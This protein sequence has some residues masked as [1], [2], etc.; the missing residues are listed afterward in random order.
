M[1]PVRDGAI[2][3]NYIA[4]TLPTYT[5]KV[6]QKYSDDVNMISDSNGIEDGN[7]LICRYCLFKSKT[8]TFVE[9]KSL[10]ARGVELSTLI[11]MVLW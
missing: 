2:N 5:V 6:R 10:E 7:I 8:E 1:R 3:Q 4:F 11:Y 9:V